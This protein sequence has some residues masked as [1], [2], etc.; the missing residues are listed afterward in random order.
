MVPEQ[1]RVRGLV[2]PLAAGEYAKLEGLDENDVL[3]A[4]QRGTLGGVYSLGWYVEAP[5]Y[6]EERL[7]RLRGESNLEPRLANWLRQRAALQHDGQFKSEIE[8]L[9]VQLVKSNWRYERL[10]PAQQQALLST[11]QYAERPQPID[12]GLSR[13]DICVHRGRYPLNE[14]LKY[15]EEQFHEW[16]WIFL[17]AFAVWACA[18]GGMLYLHSTGQ[19]KGSTAELWLLAIVNAAAS[20]VASFYLFGMTEGF[21]TAYSRRRS[22][23]EYLKYQ[24]ALELH[25]LYK[26]TAQAAVHEAEQAR[27]RTKRSYWAFLDGYEFER[28]TAEVLKRHQFNPIVTRGSADGGVDIEVTRNGLKGVVQC[29]A[30]VAGV[31]PHVVR[32]LYG[33]IH[34][35]GSDFGL[36]VSRGGFTQGAID[37]ARSKPILLV[38]VSDLIAMQ[39]GRDVLGGAFTRKEI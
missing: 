11:K 23:P 6:S 33:V 2:E 16:R 26:T 20:L 37:F 4:I 39:E 9:R 25:E 38:D 31:G 36:I 29:K 8:H 18:C 1:L 30:H 34:H 12:Y 15:R 35:S 13:H 10:T 5:P 3:E 32:D 17:V 7:S 19:L 27:L 14:D 24:E 28:A 21:A 22:R